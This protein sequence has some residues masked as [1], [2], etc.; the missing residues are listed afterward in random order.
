MY[1]NHGTVVYLLGWIVYICGCVMVW[2]LSRSVAWCVFAILLPHA[3]FSCMIYVFWYGNIRSRVS[4]DH[5]S[6][7]S[8]RLKPSVDK[9]Y[10]SL[11]STPHPPLQRRH[12]RNRSLQFD[13]KKSLSSKTA[14]GLNMDHLYVTFAEFL[15]VHYFVGLNAF[16]LAIERTITTLVRKKLFRMGWIKM[17]ACNYSVIVANLLLETSLVIYFTH[18]EER[19][20][21]TFAFFYWSK[22][23]LFTNNGDVKTPM[24]ELK[25]TIN[26][27]TRECTESFLGTQSLSMLD[28]VV[29]LTFNEIFISHPRVHAYGNWATNTAHSNPF[30]RKMSII[31]SV[32]NYFGFTTFPWTTRIFQAMGLASH[33]MKNVKKAITAG[34]DISVPSH[35][36]IHK[37]QKYSAY[38]SFILKT[39]SV[40]LRIFN[41]F[42][43]YFYGIDGEA[44]FIATVLHS[45][46][47]SQLVEIIHEPLWLIEDNKTAA[48]ACISECAQ[49]ALNGYSHSL[50]LLVFNR[51]YNNCPHPFFAEVYK[52][53]CTFNK[54]MANGMETCIIK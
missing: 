21:Q 3:L 44:L 20:H 5:P 11:N 7:A 43:S 18:L 9:T 19:N 41:N 35:T 23:P 30:I 10:S 8:H 53:V 27:T 46:S 45:L 25:I 12:T 31:T 22:F 32:Y 15:W 51:Y 2:L 42:P 48:Y 1:I 39:R 50:P 6:S 38:V 37:L 33:D 52:E 36:Q 16:S 49:L 14:E 29:L 4:R 54:H 47:H 26:L 28:T 13:R 24:E 40:F 17:T 34:L